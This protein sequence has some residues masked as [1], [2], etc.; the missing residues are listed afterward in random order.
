MSLAASKRPAPRRHAANRES[1]VPDMLRE[2]TGVLSSDRGTLA[3]D[4]YPP[5]SVRCLPPESVAKLRALLD[6]DRRDA[7]D[8]R[9][10][11]TAAPLTS[12]SYQTPWSLAP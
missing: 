11:V 8:E 7:G 2:A 10:L 12:G 5:E 4:T 3:Q 9:T 6:D 1:D